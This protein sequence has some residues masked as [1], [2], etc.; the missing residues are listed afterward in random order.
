MCLTNA[1]HMLKDV[2]DFRFGGLYPPSTESH[3]V[4]HK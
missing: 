1:N 3:N 2:P 4:P